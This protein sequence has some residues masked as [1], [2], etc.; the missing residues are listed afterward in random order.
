VRK[1]LVVDD[2]KFSRN[3]NIKLLVGLEYEIVGEAVDGLD[4]FEKFKELNPQLIVTDLEMPNLNGLD[5]IKEI[6][7]YN[8]KVDIIVISSVVNS[9]TI[10]E[11]ARLGASVIKKP[12]REIK[13]LNAI[14]L[15]NKGG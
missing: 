2:S 9:Q 13:L 5:M 11:V 12:V 6:R 14:K 1:V 4:G 3:V 10:Q 8:K 15:L 7:K